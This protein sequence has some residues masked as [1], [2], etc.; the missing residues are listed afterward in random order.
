MRTIE[1]LN[2]K[3]N[4]KVSVRNALTEQC[5][6]KVSEALENAGVE[7]EETARGTVAIALGV[8]QEGTPIYYEISGTVT[9]LPLDK[10]NAKR[11]S[12]KKETDKP[13]VPTLF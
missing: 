9:R 3:G 6:A 10:E 2:E 12:N 11:K 4:V 1:L 13:S 7:L 5:E 8:D